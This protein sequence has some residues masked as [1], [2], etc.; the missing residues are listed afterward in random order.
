[1]SFKSAWEAIR[2]QHSEAP[3]AKSVWF[4][5]AIPRHSF[6]MWLTFHKAHSTLDNLQRFG[7]VQS[8]RCP[9]NCGIDESMNHLFFECP[10]TKTVWSEVLKLNNCPFPS[11]WSWD[12]TTY[13]ALGCTKGKQ[14]HRWM[15]RLGLAAA[16]YH[17]WKERN[18]RVFRHTVA[19]PSQVMDRITFD[20]GRKASTCR[21]ILDSPTNRAITE[22]WKIEESIFSRS[23]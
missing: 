4:P 12:S 3:W 22:N 10:F 6:C 13:W 2:A 19:S 20:V 8:S 1:F 18:N 17:C 11:V 14:F 21:Y 9:F 23:C 7:I 16:I 15:R 5:G